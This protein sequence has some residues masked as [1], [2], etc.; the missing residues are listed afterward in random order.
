MRQ[1]GLEGGYSGYM[2]YLLLGILKDERPTL[3]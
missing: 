1:G 3:N 2:K